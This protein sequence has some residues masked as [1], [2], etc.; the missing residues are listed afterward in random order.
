M[1]MLL[2]EDDRPLG[3]A[4]REQLVVDGYAIDWAKDLAEARH[5]ASVADYEIILL[6]V[7]LPDGNGIDYLQEISKRAVSR[8]VMIMIMTC[9]DQTSQ[10]VEALDAGA[11]DYMVKPFD[12]DEL[13]ARI[14][15]L[16]RRRGG[17]MPPTCK[18]APLT[19]DAAERSPNWTDI[20]EALYCFG[21]EIESNTVEVDIRRLRKK[22]G[23]GLI[24]TE[25]GLGYRLVDTW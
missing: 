10:K 13:S 1:R 21:S 12:L 2:I 16:A 23:R 15:A 20:E 7:L 19:I 14:R 4:I 11:D 18:L 5:Y 22:I 25:R 6:D 24:L 3:S 8:R 17:Y 9:R